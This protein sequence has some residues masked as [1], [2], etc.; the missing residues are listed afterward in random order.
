MAEEAGVAVE[1]DSRLLEL[2]L[3]AIRTHLRRGGVV[4]LAL[5]ITGLSGETAHPPREEGACRLLI[6]AFGLLSLIGRKSRLNRV[7][8][9]LS[10]IRPDLTLPSGGA[11]D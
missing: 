4:V 3:A 11:A 10:G 2:K 7:L 9:Y 1:A 5:P 8:N 6:R